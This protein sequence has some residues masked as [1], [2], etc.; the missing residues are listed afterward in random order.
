MY[1]WDV[2]WATGYMLSF[3]SGHA[4]WPDGILTVGVPSMWPATLARGP[5][6]FGRLCIVESPDR[7]NSP[8]DFLPSLSLSASL[9][10]L[11]TCLR[12]TAVLCV[13][14]HVS[15]YW[16]HGGGAAG[17]NV[18]LRSP[19]TTSQLPN[20]AGALCELALCDAGGPISC[21][22]ARRQCNSIVRTALGGAGSGDGPCAWWL[23]IISTSLWLSINL[24]AHSGRH[25]IDIVLNVLCLPC[26]IEHRITLFGH[27]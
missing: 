5:G 10:P 2:C 7:S 8:L 24:I 12:T 14:R 15:C 21:D 20:T 1:L 9:S 27:A 13:A 26:L 23:P 3:L 19:Q 17:R 18:A 11:A 22:L 16:L 4:T 25:L 6:I